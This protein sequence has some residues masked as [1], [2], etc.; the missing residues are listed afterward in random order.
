MHIQIEIPI[1][2]TPSNHKIFFKL[3]NDAINVNVVT[4][5]S[6]I[7]SFALASINKF[8]KYYMV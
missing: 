5:Q 7:W 4:T 8:K 3:N 1:P 2:T 6:L